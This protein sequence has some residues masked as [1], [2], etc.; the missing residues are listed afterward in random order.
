MELQIGD[1]IEIPAWRTVGMVMEI[2]PPMPGTKE[3]EVLL[4][5]HPEQPPEP[6]PMGQVLVPPKI[7]PSVKTPSTYT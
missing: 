6:L 3:I 7:S 2:Q 5:E 4:Q 1:F